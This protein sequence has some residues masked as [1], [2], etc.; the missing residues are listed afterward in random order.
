MISGTQENIPARSVRTSLAASTLAGLSVLG[1][2]EDKREMTLMSYGTRGLASAMEK[3]RTIIQWSRLYGRAS[4]V[5]RRPHSHT[6][7]RQVH[8]GHMMIRSVLMILHDSHQDRNAD[9]AIWVDYVT[10]QH[11][12]RFLAQNRLNCLGATSG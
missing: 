3:S 2:S 4:N 5:H 11:V 10:S 9:D 7:H 6:G 1:V 12:D 8:A